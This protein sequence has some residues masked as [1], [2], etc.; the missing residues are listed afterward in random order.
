MDM[1]I[2]VQMLE[3]VVCVSRSDNTHR[4][5]MNP[6][7]LPPAMD[8]IVEQTGLFKLGMVT[9]LGKGKHRI[10]VGCTSL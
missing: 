10:Q 1:A 4:K 6:I 2:Q 5:G 3:E 7:I 8:E 9:S